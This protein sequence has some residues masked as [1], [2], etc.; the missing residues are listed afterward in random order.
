[1]D[2]RVVL[3]VLF[4]LSAISSVGVQCST[5]TYK[6]TLIMHLQKLLAAVEWDTLHL[7]CDM[8]ITECS[9]A[10]DVLSVQPAVYVSTDF[11]NESLI[12]QMFEE[13]AAP[14]RLN[15]LVFCDNCD[16][17]LNV[18]NVFEDTHELQGYFTY[19]YQ[20]ILVPRSRNL[21]RIEANLGNIMH[22]VVVSSDLTFYTGMFGEK[23]YLQ[24]VNCKKCWSETP[25]IS[26]KQV[27]PNIF[28]GLNNITLVLALVPWPPWTIKKTSGQYSG[29]YVRIMEMIADTL[30]FTLSIIQPDD[31]QYGVLKNG[32]WT[33]MMKQL[34]H[35][36]ADIITG[37]MVT[38][39]RS[40][41]VTPMRVFVRQTN[42][43]F[44]YHKPEPIAMSAEILVRP[45]STQVWLIFISVLVGTLI[46]FHLSQILKFQ[47]IQ[48]S[49]GSQILERQN[50][51]LFSHVNQDTQNDDDT[52][53]ST[54]KQQEEHVPQ[55]NHIA[56]T[57][58]QSHINQKI[59]TDRDLQEERQR[60]A[61]SPYANELKNRKES[62][63]D[64][65]P[66][67]ERTDQRGDFGACILRSTLNQGSTWDPFRTSTRLIYSFYTL[68]WIAIM[69]VYT[70]SLVSL[71][72]VKKE[73]IPF[74]TFS[75]LASNNEYK[76]GLLWGSMAYDYFFRN[77]FT[78]DDP[79]YHIKEK[80][81][82]DTKHDPIELLTDVDYHYERL[83]T[84]KYALFSYT[85]EFETFATTSCRVAM[86]KQKIGMSYDGFMLQKNSAYEK[87]FNRVLSKIQAGDVD[88]DLKKKFW[89]KPKQC[90]TNLNNVSLENIQ[91]VLY[92]LFGGLGVAFI[93][94]LVE[95]IYCSQFYQWM[96]RRIKHE[97]RPYQINF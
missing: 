69:A 35:K 8:G 47:K 67:A 11:R 36:E 87:D 84:E 17:L 55:R 34:V 19:T 49:D 68:G 95:N 37:L 96:F 10:E 33:G 14:T 52:L 51:S 38:H 31:G 20:W 94:L 76:L 58:I 88:K 91:G 73:V 60:T 61:C 30:N 66:T 32:Q 42:S 26:R 74:R 24:E 90:A 48:K 6:A 3:R 86:L 77:N 43:V 65:H 39:E 97:F 70:G 41:Y 27:F 62:Q 28:N 13:Y 44:I 15:W 29:Y 50:A 64:K 75:E 40:L 9:A 53:W 71:L 89:P 80:I 85:T 46:A 59:Q 72:S 81:I 5:Q 57:A 22:L 12:V 93:A 2:L 54:R 16:T 18:I 79:M 63:E 23:R 45:F 56:L 25:S 21:G 4:I 78:E 1:M 92:I 7:V 83:N 82:R